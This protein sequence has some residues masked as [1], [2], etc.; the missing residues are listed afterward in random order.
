MTENEK[1]PAETGPQL[2]IC[3]VENVANAIRKTV[4]LMKANPDVNLL[5]WA[6]ALKSV[7]VSV[8]A[9]VQANCTELLESY[10][11]KLESEDDEG[12]EP[13]V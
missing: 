2:N 9:T 10:G 8:A 3:E 6:Q 12:D 5:E 1:S 11:P 7:Q 13:T 4:E